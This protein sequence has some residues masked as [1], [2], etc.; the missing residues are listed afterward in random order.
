MAPEL[1]DPEQ[2]GINPKDA[3]KAMKASDLYALEITVWQVRGF[4]CML[5]RR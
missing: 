5:L 1:L 4:S 3:G 2:C